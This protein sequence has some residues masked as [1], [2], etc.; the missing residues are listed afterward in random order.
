[1]ET[2]EKH[3]KE[4]MEDVSIRSEYKR[5][6]TEEAEGKRLDRE[7]R[8]MSAKLWNNRRRN[9]ALNKHECITLY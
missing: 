3:I 7:S 5:L 6:Y 8:E 4:R 2:Q 9:I 1:M